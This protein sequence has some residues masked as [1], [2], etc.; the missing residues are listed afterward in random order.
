MENGLDNLCVMEIKIN[1]YV[2]KEGIEV[3][4][5]LDK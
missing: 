3:V 4:G 2:I 5:M 1:K